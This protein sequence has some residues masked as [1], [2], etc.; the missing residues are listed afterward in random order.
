MAASSKKFNVGVVGYGMSAKI[1]HIPFVNTTPSLQLHSIL[2]R[3]P[4][5]SDSAPSDYPNLQHHTSYDTFL[6]DS[7]LDVVILTTTPPTHFALAA[8]ALEA[9]K[10]VLVEKPFVPTSS[11]AGELISL[12]K[13]NRRLLC[14]YQNRRWDADYLTVKTLVQDG[15]LGR[16]V[17]FETH[18]DRYRAEKPTNWKGTVSMNEGGGAVYDLGAH[19]IDQVYALFGS[20]KSVFAKLVNQ[21]DGKLAGPEGGA[22]E[23]ET[24]SVVAELFYASGTVVHVRIGV[25]SVE[26]QQ[27]RFWV[28]GTKASYRKNGLD[29]QENQLKAGM[30]ADETSF[31]LEDSEWTGKLTTLEA[32][33]KVQE[34]NHPTVKPPTYMEFYRL[35]AKALETGKEEDVPVPATQARDVLRVIEA[36]RESSRT[37]REV[38]LTGK[39]S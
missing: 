17:E 15:T 31:G 29:P 10:H 1:F 19:L 28:R 5:S 30:K 22:S 27:P 20:P 16:I 7:S 21:R 24:D 4:K 36:V 18:F 38:S 12:A 14:V 34:R 13:K 9:G 39:T 11:E 25:M 2:Q 26:V 6:A 33:G 3:S 23:D 8:Q 32:N 35:F 37:G